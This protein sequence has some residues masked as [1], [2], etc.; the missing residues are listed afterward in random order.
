METMVELADQLF[1]LF[2]AGDLKGAVALFA[3]DAVV[4]QY[5]GPQ[6]GTPVD[7]AVFE[8]SL[9]AL[10]ANVGTPRYLRRRV[11]GFDGGFVEQHTSQLTS[12]R[13]GVVSLEVC[14]VVRTDATGRIAS[15]EEYLDPQPLKKAMMAAQAKL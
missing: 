14:V 13:N 11:A 2:E 6:A 15:L 12:A 7:I 3:P 8:R 5:F 1:N 9:A 10:I 4:M